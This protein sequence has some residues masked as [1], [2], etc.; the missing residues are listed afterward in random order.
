M[1]KQ[2]KTPPTGAA[3][4]LPQEPAIQSGSVPQTLIQTLKLNSPRG[5]ETWYIGETRKIK[6]QAMGVDGLVK[7]VLTDKSGKEKVLTPVTGV[8]VDKGSYSWKIK[9]NLKADSLYT[10]HVKSFDGKVASRKSG[11]FNIKMKASVD[12]A[13]KKTKPKVEK[14]PKGNTINLQ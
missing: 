14:P 9:S 3:V 2:M 5:M 6:W 11:G 13:R 8:S 12:A 10:I 1:K 4:T 7:V